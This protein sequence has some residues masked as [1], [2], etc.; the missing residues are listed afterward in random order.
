METKTRRFNFTRNL[1]SAGVN[2]HDSW[3]ILILVPRAVLTVYFKGDPVVYYTHACIQ[4][5]SLIEGANV[6][7]V[8]N[9]LDFG[10]VNFNIKLLEP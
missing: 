8:A 6:V 7:N 9:V 2:H 5:H 3:V 1:T 10:W 4:F